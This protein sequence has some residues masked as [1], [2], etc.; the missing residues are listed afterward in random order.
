MRRTALLAATIAG[1]ATAA[2]A[3]TP[4][5]A[6]YERT[7]MGAAHARCRLFTPD[8]AE[9]L[10]AAR[11]QAR[12]ASLRAGLSDGEVAA[13][14]QRARG[15]AG[16]VPCGSPDVAVAAARV[17]GAFQGW[18]AMGRM[19]FPGQMQGWAA[20][21][22]VGREPRWSLRQDSR[23]GFARA[24]LGLA[25]SE[26][27]EALLLA[28]EG[29]MPAS[30][31]LVTRRPAWSARPVVTGPLSARL[32]RGGAQAFTADARFPATEVLRPGRDSATVFRLPPATLQA[33]AALDPREAVAAEFVDAR[34]GVRTAWF[35]VGDFAAGRAFLAAAR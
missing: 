10:E 3:T 17:R 35:E 21:R 15:R 6:L 19:D 13:V 11:L 23:V 5:E 34:G 9:A 28:V 22:A 30:A 16:G 1:L 12:G 27:G 20:D 31:R 18:R 8:L 25:A 32:A 24:T 14:E 2:S 4:A 33:L 29:P 7:V 26:R